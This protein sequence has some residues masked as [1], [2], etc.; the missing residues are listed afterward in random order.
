MT[1]NNEERDVEYDRKLFVEMVENRTDILKSTGQDRFSLG[2]WSFSKLKVLEKCPFQFYLKYILKAKLPA[3]LQALVDTT[4]ADIGSAAHRILELIIQDK[5]LEESYAIAKSEFCPDKLSEEQWAENLETV[6]Y[7]IVKFQ[8]RIERFKIRYKVKK[9]YTE[10]RIGVTKD[11]KP[12]EFF[13][14]NVYFRGV[15]DLFLLMENHDAVLIDHKFGPPA[16]MGVRNF[17]DQLNTYKPLINYGFA[18]LNN[19][20]TGV[21]FIRDGEVVMDSPSDKEDVREKLKVGLEWN[22]DGAVD[23]V[24]EMGFYKHKRG[25]HCVYCEYNGL[26]KPGQLKKVEKMTGKFFQIHPE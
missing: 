26:C 15:I 25:P 23:A 18:E 22:L 12:A 7:N 17:R 10:V 9:I 3:S 13:G 16:V 8:E 24:K 14:S 5:N 20:S 2:A 4:A 21:H 1:A 19:A 6:E 11:W